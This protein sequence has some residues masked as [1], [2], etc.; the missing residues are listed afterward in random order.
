MLEIEA[1]SQ[2]DTLEIF[3][4][5][6][7]ARIAASFLHVGIVRA[8]KSTAPSN[9][10]QV[11]A[12]GVQVAPD[13]PRLAVGIDHLLLCAHPLN[14]RSASVAP[15]HERLRFHRKGRAPGCARSRR[16]ADAFNSGS[17]GA[18]AS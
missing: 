14:Q 13:Y 8:G 16:Y 10:G 3:S 17:A 15:F 5:R 12:F 2:I 9:G 7:H 1:E 4:P 18:L 6:S 11:R